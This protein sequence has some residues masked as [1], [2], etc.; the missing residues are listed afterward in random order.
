[1]SKY[2]V[3]SGPYF[4]EFS[5]NTGKYGPEITQY[6]DTFHAV[7]VSA[8][9]DELVLQNGLKTFFHVTLKFVRPKFQSRSL[10]RFSPC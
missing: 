8:D 5:Q 7:Y 2:G 10:W 3:I 9:D 4:P 6:L 1:M